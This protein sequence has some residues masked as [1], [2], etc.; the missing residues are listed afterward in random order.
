MPE[1]ATDTQLSAL[2][3]DLRKVRTAIDDATREAEYF[4]EMIG[5]LEAVVT[6]LVI[7]AV[8][9]QPDK[10]KA[11][12]LILERAEAFVAEEAKGND[13]FT[14]SLLLGKLKALQK[15]TY[16]ARAGTLRALK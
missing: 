6:G 8:A 10:A 4:G 11:R 12:A 15:A 14:T 1:Y 9:T 3:R 7:T 5:F 16:P 13:T 2:R